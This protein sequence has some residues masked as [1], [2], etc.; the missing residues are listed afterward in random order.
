MPSNANIVRLRRAIV[1]GVPISP[2]PT[3][4]APLNSLRWWFGRRFTISHRVVCGGWL[5][6]VE[7]IRFRSNRYA[8]GETLRK[9]K[10]REEDCSKSLVNFKNSWLLS[11]F[12]RMI[13]AFHPFVYHRIL[14]LW[15]G[16]R[17]NRIIQGTITR[18]PLIQRFDSTLRDDAMNV[19]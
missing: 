17:S 5:M 1:S 18:D 10:S 7:S 2:L 12:E 11:R 3:P 8:I 9:V 4:T 13:R 16:I 19:Y 15:V 6:V 14:Y